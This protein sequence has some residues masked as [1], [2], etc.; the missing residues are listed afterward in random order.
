MFKL[1]HY[2]SS[3]PKAARERVTATFVSGPQ[4]YKAEYVLN[5]KVVGIRHFHETG[6][7]AF[8]QPLK[9]GLLH[10][11]VYRSDEPG[12][13]TSAEPYRNGLP[14]GIA[15]QW[16]EDGK[17][18]GTY[19]MKHGTGVDLW[20]S[21][22]EQDRPPHLTEVRH[23]HEGK[24]HGV[25]WWLN[26][27]HSLWQ[28]HHFWNN[29]AHGIERMWNLHGRL[30]RGYPRYWVN[31][32]RVTKRQYIRACANDPSLPPFREKDNRPHRRFPPEIKA[33]LS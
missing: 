32:V 16:S 5:G 15:K 19:S 17:L 33:R 12:K 18:I 28:E 4:K 21:R 26:E 24:R 3:I 23:L 14:H 10:G 31:D 2:R 6:E 8:E 11:T 25:E 22:Y 27:D 20:W 9:N 29:H 13:L 7:L 30:R 1:K